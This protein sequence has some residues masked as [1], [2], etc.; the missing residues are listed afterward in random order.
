MCPDSDT[1]RPSRCKQEV[2]RLTLAVVVLIAS[3]AAEARDTTA[4]QDAFERLTREGKFSGAVVIRD[5]DGVRF[6]QG[7][8][9]ADPFS[10]RRFTPETPVDSASLAKPVAAAAVL[11][12]VREG[13]LDLD[14]RCVAICAAIRIREREAKGQLRTESGLTLPTAHCH[15]LIAARDVHGCTNAAED[16]MS[17]SC[18]VHGCTNAAE[19][20]MSAS[21]LLPTRFD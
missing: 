3:T 5:A 6:A 2:K 19:D 16:R 17:A 10:E 12:L 9:F 11:L 20:R 18:D 13:K 1:V 14:A 21:C 4:L 8:G 7:F 15:W